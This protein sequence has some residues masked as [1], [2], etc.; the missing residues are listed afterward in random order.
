M[1]RRS[2]HP[3]AQQPDPCHTRCNQC[4]VVCSEAILTTG[5]DW[6]LNS[7]S[8]GAETLLGYAAVE[9]I[10]RPLDLFLKEGTA[11]LLRIREVLASSGTVQELESVI[12]GKNKGEI[13]VRLSA[14]LLRDGNGQANGFIAMLHDLSSIRHLESEMA[15]KDQFFASILKNSADAIITLDAEERVTSWNKGAEATFGYTEQEMLGRSLDVLMPQELK[16]QRE[17]ET[18]SA[19]ARSEGLLRSYQTQRLAKDGQ[20]IDVL[21]TR[22]AIRDPEGNL[23]GFSSVL[24]NVSEQK[25]LDRHLAQ[26]EKLSAIGELAAGLAHEIKNPLAGIKGAIEIIRESM[27]SAHPHRQILGEVL[28][29]VGRIDR[30][31]MNLLSYSKPKPPDFTKVDLVRVI[32]NVVSF[33]QKIADSKG[34]RLHTVPS[35]ESVLITGDENELKQL[36]MNLILN[37]LEAIEKQGNIWIRLQTSADF[38]VNIEIIDDGPGI[39]PEQLPK[40]F[41]PFFTSKKHGT[42]LGLATCKR[43]V[44]NHGGE[45]RVDSEVGRGT[46]F[47][48]DLCL[49]SRIPMSL[50][51]K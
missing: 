3:Q 14:S 40:V 33:V 37:S 13:P 15:R 47:T 12:L 24:K 45:I 21:F 2:P 35:S 28:S 34:I 43:I 19:V 8:A 23:I 25:L 49:N 5:P 29:E 46:R 30:S 36:F 42:G 1:N 9:A 17:L 31:V 10:G 41:L 44:T 51:G 32:G 38:H 26:M 48:I 7:Y 39:A 27:A 6:R 18:I 20:I 4:A 50:P 16:E 22:T 11:E